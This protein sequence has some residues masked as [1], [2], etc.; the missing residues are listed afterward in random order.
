MP[1]D[2]ST[3]TST[4]VSRK[5]TFK[6]GK[7]NGK[8]EVLVNPDIKDV[9]NEA[10]EKHHVF[11]FGRLNPITSGHEALVKKIHE[12]AKEHDAGH[13]LVVSHS[14]DSKKNPLAADQKVKHASRAF[15]NTNILAS[16]KEH[17]T[18]LHHAANIHSQGV[19]HLHMI[20]GSDRVD[21]YKEKLNKYNDNKEHPF[22]K[23][24]FK[25]ITVHSSGER[26]PDSEGASGIS[27]SKMRE[28]ASKGDRESF[29]A[30]APSSMN[31]KHKDEMYNDTRKG[32]GIHEQT[33]INERVVNVQQRR[34]RAIQM[35]RLGTRLTRARNIA[36][37]RM[38]SPAQI[39]RRA[40]KAAK[41]NIRRRVAGARGVE[42]QNLSTT[43]KYAVDVIVDPRVKNIR[44]LVKRIVPRIRQSEVNRLAAV[45]TH[46]K[47]IKAPIPQMQSVDYDSFNKLYDRVFK[48][49]QSMHNVTAEMPLNNLNESFGALYTAKDLGIVAEGGFSMHPSVQVNLDEDA[50]SHLQQAAIA[51]RTGRHQKASIHRNIAAA[52]QRGDMTAAKSLGRQ[53]ST[54]Q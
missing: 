45:K 44:N 6:L 50:A 37:Q 42:Y 2:D 4:P 25:S 15:S 14:Q 26:D 52:L 33:E 1:L 24:N 40:Y 19:K 10:A 41:Q 49:S 13:T 43:G 7:K 9:M 11:A 31:T 23:M 27:A 20:A 38:A 36:R 18:F 8:V 5:N 16:S 29:H 17:P 28:F 22:G 54:V 46:K 51:E 35:R 3:S 12:V 21:E 48:D 30:N 53:L 39:E 47:Y 32:M 34:K